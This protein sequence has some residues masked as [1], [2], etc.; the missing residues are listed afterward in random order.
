MVAPVICPCPLRG[1]EIVR[2]G[3]HGVHWLECRRCGAPQRIAEISG[4]SR[5]E[6]LEEKAAGSSAR[7]VSPPA[8]RISRQ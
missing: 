8:A 6:N 2:R 4:S 3:E 7:G 1:G 5:R